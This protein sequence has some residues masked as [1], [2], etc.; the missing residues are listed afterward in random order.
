MG[1]ISFTSYGLTCN[2]PS[3]GEPRNSSVE[4]VK[5]THYRVKEAVA[6]G[7]QLVAFPE[8]NNL[9]LLGMLPGIEAMGDAPSQSGT[10][11][12]V[13]MFVGP[14]LLLRIAGE[15]DGTNYHKDCGHRSRQF[16]A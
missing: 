7:A 8:Y 11:F 13:P 12:D 15:D 16:D 10:G 2:R 4:H 1:V 5:T 9:A 14:D 6:M 3:P